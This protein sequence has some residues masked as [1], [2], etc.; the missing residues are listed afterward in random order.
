VSVAP[1]KTSS[2]TPTTIRS[3]PDCGRLLLQQW[4]RQSK[5][6]QRHPWCTPLL[7][8]ILALQHW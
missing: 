7:L 6:H 8:G 5:L 4:E 3:C 1:E 2:R